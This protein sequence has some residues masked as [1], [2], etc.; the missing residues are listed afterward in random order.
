MKTWTFM[1]P[2][3]KMMKIELE[4]DTTQAQAIDIIKEKYK[5]Q[6]F[7]QPPLRFYTEEEFNELMK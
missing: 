1:L 7:V 5:T 2:H 6:V 4:D 3:H